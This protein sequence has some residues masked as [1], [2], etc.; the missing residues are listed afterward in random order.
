MRDVL[1]INI[2]MTAAPRLGVHINRG[3]TEFF[4]SL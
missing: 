3:R 2:H 1:F 4:Q